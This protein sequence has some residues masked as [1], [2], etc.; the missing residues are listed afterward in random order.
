VE[1]VDG[2]KDVRTNVDAGPEL[3]G[4]MVEKA[5]KE[6]LGFLPRGMSTL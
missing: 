1:E 2:V 6:A 3:T 5:L 4:F